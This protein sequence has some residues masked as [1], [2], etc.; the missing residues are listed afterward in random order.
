[1]NLFEGSV[2]GVRFHKTTVEW[3]PKSIGSANIFM[4]PTSRQSLRKFA[5]YVSENGLA[6]SQ[7]CSGLCGDDPYD[8]PECKAQTFLAEGANTLLGSYRRKK[9]PLH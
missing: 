7:R 9:I 1:M 2:S 8:A 4:P 3:D 5:Y 6:C